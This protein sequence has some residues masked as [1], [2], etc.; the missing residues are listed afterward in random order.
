MACVN[1]VSRFYLQTHML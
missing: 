1:E